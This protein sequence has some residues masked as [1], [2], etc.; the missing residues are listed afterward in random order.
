MLQHGAC[1]AGEGLA[2]GLPAGREVRVLAHA[3]CVAGWEEEFQRTSSARPQ[4]HGPPRMSRNS[5]ESWAS[6]FLSMEEAGAAAWPAEWEATWA[7]G[8]MEGAW[9]ETSARDPAAHEAAWGEAVEMDAA[10]TAATSGGAKWAAE[11]DEEAARIARCAGT[12]G[13]GI[14]GS[15]CSVPEAGGWR[16][17]PAHASL[18]LLLDL[19]C[20]RKAKDA[21]LNDPAALTWVAQFNEAVLQP[22][23]QT[24][25]GRECSCSALRFFSLALCT[26]RGEG[27]S[28]EA[29][30]DDA[31]PLTAPF[32][33]P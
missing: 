7:G 4:Q 8:V 3:P 21:P 16:P 27:L 31:P 15:A 26:G 9:K 12:T 10:W 30:C 14:H 18:G 11:F 25:L 20:C 32:P 22:A 6:G 23:P 17:V 29:P 33:P 28:E 19:G 1:V 2:D 5:T 24:P 13:T